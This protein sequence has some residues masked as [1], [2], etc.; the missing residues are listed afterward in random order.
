MYYCINQATQRR[1]DV[2]WNFNSDR[3]IYIQLVEKLKLK[4]I[5]GVYKKGE[6]MPPVRD[7]AFESKVNPNTMQKALQELE[8]SDLVRVERT[9]GRF[10]T[11]D[12]KKIEK[13]RNK[14]ANEYVENYLFAMKQLGMDKKEAIQ[15]LEEKEKIG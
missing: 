4:I 1:D 11:D 10:V 7:L 5:T 9:V 6:K 15:F 2:E 8:T 13:C 14:I 12:L 3:P